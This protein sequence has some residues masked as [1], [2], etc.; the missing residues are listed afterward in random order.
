MGLNVHAQI[1][2]IDEIGVEN[3]SPQSLVADHAED[4]DYSENGIPFLKNFSSRDYQAQG[5]NWAII[6]DRNGFMYFGNTDGCV[7]QYDGVSW[8]K[9]PVSNGSIV[10][11]LVIDSTGVI[12][13]GAQ[14]EVGYLS[15]DSI[16]TLRYVSL[17][18]MIDSSYH[19]F[20]N[21][22]SLRHNAVV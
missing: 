1:K 19:N 22:C 13:V 11:S 12:Y 21:V 14:N 4:L 5:Q 15:P 16:G 9:I 8:R 7:L 6:Q 20:G 10:R 2:S 17:M 18:N 3:K